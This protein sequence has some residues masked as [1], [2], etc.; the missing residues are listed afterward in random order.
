MVSFSPVYVLE[1]L[2]FSFVEVG[3]FSW[4]HSPWCLF[5]PLPQIRPGSTS[6]E[7]VAYHFHIKCLLATFQVT[8][9]DIFKVTW[10][11][12]HPF[13]WRQ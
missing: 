6:V 5:L 11:H 9:V 2:V 3:E 1:L 12:F 10:R 8:L 4:S 13:L 7:N